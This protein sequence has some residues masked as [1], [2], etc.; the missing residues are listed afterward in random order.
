MM[1]LNGDAGGV[2]QRSLEFVRRGD[3]VTRITDFITNSLSCTS[4]PD[5]RNGPDFGG[6]MPPAFNRYAEP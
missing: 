1:L 6:I 4:S 5:L 3:G 2:G